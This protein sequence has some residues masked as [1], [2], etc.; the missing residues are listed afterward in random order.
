MAVVDPHVTFKVRVDR[1]ARAVEEIQLDSGIGWHLAT[2]FGAYGNATLADLTACA[3]IVIVGLPARALG[4]TEPSTMNRFLTTSVE[5]G[6]L[7]RSATPF[8]SGN[9]CE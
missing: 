4:T 1:L 6:P 7:L 3:V 5:T 8:Q 2:P 9:R